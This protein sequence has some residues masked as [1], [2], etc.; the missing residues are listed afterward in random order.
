MSENKV[1]CSWCEGDALYEAYHDQEWGVP[2][3]DDRELFEMLT[4]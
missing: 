1:R 3:S 4:L 2:T